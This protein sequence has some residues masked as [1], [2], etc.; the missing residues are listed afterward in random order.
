VPTSSLP[1]REP[2]SPEDGEITL[3]AWKRSQEETTGKRWSSIQSAQ[4]GAEL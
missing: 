1:S 3:A 4:L 2:A